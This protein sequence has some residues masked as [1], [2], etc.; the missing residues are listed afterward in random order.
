M[1]LFS[2]D[3]A[4]PTE[5]MGLHELPPA[6]WYH[7]LPRHRSFSDSTVSHPPE[8]NV[9]P[10]ALCA[11]KS[12]ILDLDETLI[13]SSTFPPH[14][15]VEAFRIGD[16]E[17]YVFKR[18]GLDIF[19]EDVR[20]KFEVFVFTHG[21]EQYAKPIIDHLMPWLADDH[22][23]YREA[24]DGR[25]GPRKDLKI[26]GRSKQDLILIDDSECALAMNPQNTVKIPRWCGSPLDRVLIE[27]LPPILENC[28]TAADVRTVIGQ[29]ESTPIES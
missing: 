22:R 3:T 7:K 13:H 25:H 29:I 18:P 1:H 12:L 27:W 23:L 8:F 21:A 10:S 9:T 17:F 20:F 26:F 5:F 6:V 14:S 4:L 19:L 16:P 28:A 11:K 2:T 24:C 15:R